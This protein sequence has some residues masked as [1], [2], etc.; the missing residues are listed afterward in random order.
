ML[1][2]TQKKELE[3]N[4]ALDNF[5]SSGDDC[6]FINLDGKWGIKCFT[7]KSTRNISYLCQQYASTF[8]MAPK[9]AY[10]FNIENLSSGEENYCHMTE[11]ATPLAAWGKLNKNCDGGCFSDEPEYDEYDEDLDADYVAPYYEERME[12]VKKFKRLT[13]YKYEDFHT[14][15]FGFLNNKLVCIDFTK[16]TKLLEIIEGLP[17]H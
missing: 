16:T 14:G 9:V 17:C 11:I 8:D 10:K 5:D 6:K 13:G 1:T 4:I 15:N 12:W 7:F 2:E 3:I